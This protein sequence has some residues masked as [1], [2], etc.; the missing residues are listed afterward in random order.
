MSLPQASRDVSDRPA[1]GSVVEPINR[2]RK[3]A[4][5]DRKLRL[6]GVA[7]AMRESRLPT[8][9]QIDAMLDYSLAH[10]P[11]P[12]DK[13]SESGR[14][15]IQDVREILETT[16]QIVKEKNADELL[17]NFVWHTRNTDTS[18]AKKDPNEVVPV[19]QDKIQ[20]DADQ[21]T[22]H[23]RTLA[24]LVL[25]NAEVR[26]LVSDFGIIG[27]D[28]LAHGASK[29]AELARP[30]E[31]R[32]RQVD[33][34]APD[35]KFISEGGREIGPN[36][37]PVPEARVPGTEHRIAQDP[38]SELGEGTAIKT[39]SGDVIRG[40]EAADQAQQTKQELSERA[41]YEAQRQKE[42]VQENIYDNDADV[43]SKRVRFQNKVAGVRDQITGRVPEEHRNKVNEHA[44]RAKNF[45]SDEYFPQERRDQLVYR[46]KKVIIECQNHKDYQESIRWLLDTSAEYV[47]HGQTVADHGKDSHQQLTSDSNLKQATYELRTLLER[48]AGGVSL[49]IIGD[50]MRA[51]YEDSRNDEGLRT[52]FREVNE[53][54]RECLMQPGYVLDDQCNERANQLRESGRQYYDGKYQ[55][56][57]DNLWSELADWF[58]AWGDD[59]L[60]RR[61]GQ[62]WARLTKDLLFDSEGSLKFKPELWRDIRKVILPSMIDQVGYVP[63][64]RIEYTDDSLDLVLENLALSGRNVFP[65]LVTLDAHNHMK[66][67]PYDGINDEQHHE[68]VL[69]L[70]QIQADLRDVAF[71]YHK[72][73]GMPKM[74]DSGIADVLLG[75]SGM[76]ITA[77]LASAHDPTSVFA[78]KDVT[79]KV[80]TLKFAV[81]DS[82][83]D[84]LY[85]TLAP[86]ATGLV[87]RQLQKAV[88]GAV[89]TALEY[90]DG[91]LV[92]VRDQ[93]A[94][95][96]ASED[97]SRTQVL[98]QQLAAKKDKAQGKTEEKG[99]QFKVVAQ[100]GTEI[101]PE[102][103]HPEGWVGRA[104]ERVNV[105]HK[106]E[107]WRSD[108]YNIV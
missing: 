50:A 42:D 21:A 89:R 28:L 38:S 52:W 90:L 54:A 69:T 46:L 103:G 32:L 9:T 101:M 105:A 22:Q 67:S 33:E 94:E 97:G 98:K 45:L 60:N 2:D 88:G 107:E 23:L 82:K 3:N 87:K 11:V 30:D 106:G 41:R 79:V 39:E 91:E 36:E 43:T 20:A 70:G 7:T 72:K 102:Q 37:T 99:G 27:R 17:Q 61:F 6:Y 8:N 104:R 85:K 13:L 5:V 48:F 68:F 81:R 71:F 65:N 58:A 63:I 66:F 24:S 55:G 14:T 15:L 25:T 77:H 47:S 92:A 26:K 4:D 76:T 34:P 44:T 93:M 1:Q 95:A 108:A 16:R 53:F 84:A 12:T 64:P 80:D 73:T 40:D 59:P 86:L 100:P 51:L 75:G 10:S 83:H 74:S 29:A 96:K 31:E 49:D 18:R 57:F 56:H 19:S 35:H 78:V 62:D